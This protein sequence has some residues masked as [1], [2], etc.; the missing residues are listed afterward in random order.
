MAARRRAG[1]GLDGRV[2]QMPYVNVKMYP[3]RTDDQK[4]QLAERIALAAAEICKLTDVHQTTVVIEEV[5][6]EEWRRTIVPELERLDAS[7]Y[8]P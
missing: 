1:A 2:T 7:R 8:Y 3:G 5:T 6:P 4:R